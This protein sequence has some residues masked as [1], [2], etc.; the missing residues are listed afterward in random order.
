MSMLV[1]DHGQVKLLVLPSHWREVEEIPEG[2]VMHGPETRTFLLDT[3]PGV[4]LCF[5]FRGCPL[6]VPDAKAFHALLRLP[7]H[8]LSADELEAV[9]MV[10]REASEPEYFELELLRTQKLKGKTIL[11]MEGLWKEHKLCDLGLYIDADGTGAI[12]QELHYL[13]PPESYENYRSLV[14]ELLSCIEWQ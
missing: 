12:V 10:I 6:P 2:P 3:H 1:R 8:E 13:A 5:Y 9:S 7:A 14:L 11:V 4:R